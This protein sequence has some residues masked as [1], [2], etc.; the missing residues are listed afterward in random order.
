MAAWR[1]FIIKEFL[2]VSREEIVATLAAA[3]ADRG[4]A[5]PPASMFAWRES[6]E[7]LQDALELVCATRD[8]DDWGILFEYE[9]PRRGLRPD[10]V[11]LA[12]AK[13]LVIEFKAG[14]DRF[15]R[16]SLMQANEYAQDIR[17]FHQRSSAHDIVPVLVA[18]GANHVRSSAAVEGSALRVECVSTPIQMAEFLLEQ[19]KSFSQQ[20]D[21]T[22]WDSSGYQPTPDILSAARDVFAGHNV[23][24]LSFSYA[25][26]LNSTVDQI[27]DVI[28]AS[29]MHSR[30]QVVFV[31][32]VPGSG[33]TLA[34][35]SAV[36][37]ITEDPGGHGEP[38]GAYLSGNGPLVDVLQYALSVDLHQ[39]DSVTKTEANRRAKTF[40]QPIHR[41]ILEYNDSAKVPPD[42]VIVFDEAQRAWDSAHMGRKQG[43]FKSEAEIILDAMDRIRPWAVLV[44]LVGEGQEINRG[45][46]GIGEWA[47][48]LAERP[49]WGINSAPDVAAHFEGLSD[50]VT[51]SDRLHLEVSVRSPRARALADWAD[52]LVNGNLDSAGKGAVE[53]P[54]YPVLLTRSLDSMRNYLRDR[55]TTGRRTGLLASSQARRL[56]P[57]G[58]E[59]SSTFQGGVDWPRWFVDGESDVRSSFNLEIAASEFK[60]QGLEIDW[61]GL[62]W[63]DDFFW[64]EE[65]NCWIARRLSGNRWKYDS[66]TTH[67]RNRYRVLLTRARYGLVIWVP[68]PKGHELLVDSE[69]F[70]QTVNALLEAGASW[71]IEESPASS[72]GRYV[73]L[74]K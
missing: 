12:G 69:P 21:L 72:P 46:A 19:S 10:A 28:Q 20:I 74:E 42:Q 23:R 65:V 5:T 1:K 26:N 4:L 61:A 32:G 39:R 73:R 2:T 53:F 71:L 47:R 33:K 38:L 57:F 59:M 49:G 63:G 31:T 55:A 64:S 40:I 34:G 9:I 16:A 18:T 44:A 68:K 51:I 30:H 7:L 48:A 22:E 67:A 3:A 36:H 58:I 62:C 11:I 8:T 43:V 25:D 29:S 60:C 52:N 15:D 41:Y 56:T 70:E 35:L 17:D 13:I 14:S 27:R 24:D 6:I 54:E 50:R 66:D 45:E 37:H